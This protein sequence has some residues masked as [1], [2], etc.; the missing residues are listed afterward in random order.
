MLKKYMIE[1]VENMQSVNESQSSKAVL[2]IKWEK[3]EMVSSIAEDP[4]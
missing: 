2:V 3:G 1:S 4:T